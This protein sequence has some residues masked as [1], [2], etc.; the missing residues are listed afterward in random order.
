M[1]MKKS[2]KIPENVK[3][4]VSEF[5]ITVSGEKGTLER[6]FYS[7]LFRK[8]ITIQKLNSNIEVLSKS[9]KRKI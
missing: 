5:K 4:E 3:V 8:E 2:L 9:D 7:P 6:D 1:T